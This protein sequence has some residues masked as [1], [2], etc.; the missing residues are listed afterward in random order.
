M[1]MR[2]SLETHDPKLSD[3][4]HTLLDETVEGDTELIGLFICCPREIPVDMN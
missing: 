4:S 3:H 2:S 1:S